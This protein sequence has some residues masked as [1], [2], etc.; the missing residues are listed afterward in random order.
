M[1]YKMPVSPS[2]LTGKTRAKVVGWSEA[3]SKFDNQPQIQFEFETERATRFILWINIT[4]AKSVEIFIKA[5]ILKQLSVEEFEIV[6]TQNQPFL[7][8]TLQEGKLIEFTKIG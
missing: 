6:E 1:A 2:K 8:V 3:V 4:S 5:G 7:W